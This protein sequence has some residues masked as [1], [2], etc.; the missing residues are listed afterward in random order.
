[1][2]VMLTL[3]RAGNN[4]VS[5]S[6][7]TVEDQRTLTRAIEFKSNINES[8]LIALPILQMIAN[9]ALKQICRESGGNPAKKL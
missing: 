3:A 1:M 4:K 9:L 8:I 6:V 7:I 5:E 2:P